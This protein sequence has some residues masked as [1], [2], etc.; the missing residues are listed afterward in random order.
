MSFIGKTFNGIEFYL[1]FSSNFTTFF[2]AL[3]A[4]NNQTMGKAHRLNI[5]KQKP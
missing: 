5:K 4:Q 1:F 3:K 2:I